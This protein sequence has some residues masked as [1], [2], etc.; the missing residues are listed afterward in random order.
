[1]QTFL[2]VKVYFNIERFK[3]CLPKVEFGDSVPYGNEK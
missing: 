3:K 1:M 2:L